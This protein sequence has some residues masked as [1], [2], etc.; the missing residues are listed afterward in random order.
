MVAN[1]SSVADDVRSCCRNR[2]AVHTIHNAVALEE[3]TP[4]GDCLDLDTAA[5]MP[6][7]PN[8]IVRIGLVSTMAWWKGQKDFIRAISL[9]PRCAP[10]RAYLIGGLLYQ[11]DTEQ[12]TIAELR[13]FATSLGVADRIG[14]TGFVPRPAAAI[15]TVD[16]VVHASNKPE[17][18]GRVIVE[19]MACAKPVISTAMGGAAELVEDGVTALTYPAGDANVLA[20][21]ILQL[22]ADPGLRHRLGAAGRAIAVAKFDRL[23]L[24][25][26]LSPVYLEAIAHFQRA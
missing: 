14:F 5:G 19:A 25:A 3:F 17:P 24:G 12:F 26:V 8:G 22:A 9:V 11:T 16:I 10:I 13:Q 20:A 2:R 18:F 23:R 4:E 7:C 15:R 6:S 1:S 21:R